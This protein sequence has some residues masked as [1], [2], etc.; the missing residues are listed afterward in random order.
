[1]KKYVIQRGRK[2]KVKWLKLP[3]RKKGRK[4]IG[5][6]KLYGEEREKENGKGEKIVRRREVKIK[7]ERRKNCTERSGKKMGKEKNLYGE[8]R[9]KNGK[10]EKIVRRGE[11]KRK[12]EC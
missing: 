12:W 1:L 8:E 6:K 4:K 3:V 11:G 5:E 2:K 7:W 9:E 10:G